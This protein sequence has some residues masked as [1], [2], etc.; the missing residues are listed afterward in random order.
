MSEVSFTIEV[1]EGVSVVVA[2]PE[3]DI[4][5]A[6]GFRVTLLEASA[7]ANS[8]LVVDLSGTDFCDS[9]GLNVLVREHERAEAAGGAVFLAAPGEAVRRIFQVTGIDRFLRT[10]PSLDAALR[11][12]AAV[13]ASADIG[14]L[15]RERA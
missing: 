15:D 5:N 12:A 14:R 9:M 11:D 3:I 1:L 10:S 4:T 6:D 13:R 8:V 7:A 2:P